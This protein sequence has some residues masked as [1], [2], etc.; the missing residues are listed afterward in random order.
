MY[1]EADKWLQLR[2][3]R[4]RSRCTIALCSIELCY[5]GVWCLDLRVRGVGPPIRVMAHYIEA[6]LARFRTVPKA[7]KYEFWRAPPSPAPARS[8]QYVVD[9]VTLQ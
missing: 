8:K 1:G 6:Y 2:P 4:C 9:Q 7:D 3:R 5:Q